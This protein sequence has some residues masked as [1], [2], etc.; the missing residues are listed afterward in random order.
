VYGDIPPLKVAD[1]VDDCRTLIGDGKADGALTV[2]AGLT[3]TV[4]PAE[5]E[6]EGEYAESVTLYEYVVVDLGEGEY[7]DD[8]IAPDMRLLQ[9]DPVY[10]L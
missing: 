5:H 9:L 8:V 10:H 6:D 4:S 7:V 1:R 2:R 3:V